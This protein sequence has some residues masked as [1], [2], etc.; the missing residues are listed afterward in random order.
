[1]DRQAKAIMHILIWMLLIIFFLSCTMER[2]LT[3]KETVA[4]QQKELRWK[5]YKK[6][7]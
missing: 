6:M 1:M 3:G 5:G 7:K 2:Q 4:K